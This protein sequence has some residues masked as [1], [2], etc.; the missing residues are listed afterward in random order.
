MGFA[1]LCKF[2][3]LL[4]VMSSVMFQSKVAG[5]RSRKLFSYISSVIGS[6]SIALMAYGPNEGEWVCS[7][8]RR[9]SG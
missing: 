9:C 1:E 6:Y 3:T 5:S 2:L 4:V 7:V 8:P